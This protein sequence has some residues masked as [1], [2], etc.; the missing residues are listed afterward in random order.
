MGNVFIQAQLEPFRVDQDE[1]QVI[2]TCLIEDRHQKRIDEHTLARAR[3]AGDKQVGHGGQF[4][5][6]NPPVQIAPH[7]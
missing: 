2:G 4:R 1:L 7:R 5:H 6:A 3:R